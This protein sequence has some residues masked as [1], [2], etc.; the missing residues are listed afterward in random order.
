MRMKHSDGF[1]ANLHVRSLA[2]TV[3]VLCGSTAG[4][5]AERIVPTIGL[6]WTAGGVCHG[7][8]GFLAASGWNTPRPFRWAYHSQQTIF[9]GRA[10]HVACAS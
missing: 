8:G 6:H 1:R 5:V 3:C 7:D 10:G 9:V 4:A 2:E